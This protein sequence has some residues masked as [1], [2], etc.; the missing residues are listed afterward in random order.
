L[1]FEFLSYKYNWL[2]NEILRTISEVINLGKKKYI[3]QIQSF[4]RVIQEHLDKM[5]KEKLKNNPNQKLLYYWEKE[6]E[7]FKKEI[8]KSEKRL[9]RG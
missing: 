8:V 7:K 1:E 9:S 3:K 2:E 6:I 5:Y 4:H